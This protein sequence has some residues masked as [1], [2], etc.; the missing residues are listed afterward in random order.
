MLIIVARDANDQYFPLDF[1][2]IETKTKES[3]R[4]FITL[5]LEDIEDIATN[6]WVF[7]FDKQKVLFD[8]SSFKMKYVYYIVLFNNIELRIDFVLDIYT[9]TLEKIWR[10]SCAKRLDDRCYQSHL[11]GDI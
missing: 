3:W 6:K 9:T 2:V 7:I 5:L 1:A 4:W 11:Y 10:K 8:F